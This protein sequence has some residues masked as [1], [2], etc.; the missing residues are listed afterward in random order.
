MPRSLG[1][2]MLSE[3]FLPLLQEH[4]PKMKWESSIATIQHVG[5]ATTQ[6]PVQLIGR[7]SEY[8]ED[9]HHGSPTYIDPHVFGNPRYMNVSTAGTSQ[10]FDVGDINNPNY[11]P[12]KTLDGMK[13]FIEK[14]MDR[15]DYYENV[16]HRLWSGIPEG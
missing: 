3:V 16:A 15:K 14:Y 8:R 2:E 1:E 9:R 11:D 13:K 10:G 4:Y 12:E 5:G 7:Y 6:A